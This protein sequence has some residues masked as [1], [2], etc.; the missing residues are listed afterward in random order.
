MTFNET[1]FIRNVINDYINSNDTDCSIT[2]NKHFEYLIKNNNIIDIFNLYINE[3]DIEDSKY[4]YGNNY[5][6]IKINLILYSKVINYIID[7]TKK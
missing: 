6:E 4:R 3:I 7:K 1:V 2:Y 5:I